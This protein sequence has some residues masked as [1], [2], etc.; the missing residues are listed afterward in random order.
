MRVSMLSLPEVRVV[1]QAPDQLIVLRAP[2]A[3]DGDE[4]YGTQK[5]LVRA[6]EDG[7]H[8]HGL[9]AKPPTDEVLVLL[10]D[11]ISQI[12]I[13]LLSALVWT[14]HHQNIGRLLSGT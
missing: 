5:G 3:A 7:E 11:L 1:Q 13:L 6:S 10:D 4:G 8:H 9:V 2:L 12:S 14:R